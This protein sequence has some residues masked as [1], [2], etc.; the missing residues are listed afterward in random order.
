MVIERSSFLECPL[1]YINASTDGPEWLFTIL[2]VTLQKYFISAL[3][4]STPDDCDHIW[5]GQN[6]SRSIYWSQDFTFTGDDGVRAQ[7]AYFIEFLLRFVLQFLGEFC[8][9]ISCYWLLLCWSELAYW[10]LIILFVMALRGCRCLMLKLLMNQE[11][12]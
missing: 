2:I 1:Q 10:E 11:N 12:T 9:K 6:R 7:E 4:W 3:K 5:R 8:L